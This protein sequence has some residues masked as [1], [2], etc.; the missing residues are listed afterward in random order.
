MNAEII[1]ILDNAF[2]FGLWCFLI[3]FVLLLLFARSRLRA[4]RKKLEE[5]YGLDSKEDPAAISEKSPWYNPWRISLQSSLL[6]ILLGLFGTLIYL[7]LPLP[8]FENFA[9]GS[10]WKIVPL[11][12]TAISYD[13][14]YEGFS[15]EGE[16]WN[17]TRDEPL[18]LTARIEVVGNDDKPLDE[19]ETRVKPSPLEPGKAGTFEIRYTEYSPFIKG[20]RVAFFSVDGRRIPHLTGFDVE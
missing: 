14:F 19:I 13:R 4:R 15:L 20:Y 3:S 1:R 7:F 9:A 6:A 17:Q 5:L 18:E 12:V 11:R 10:E 2:S 8:F 16:V